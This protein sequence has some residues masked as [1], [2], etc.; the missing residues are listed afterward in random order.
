VIANL[1]SLEGRYTLNY[2]TYQALGWTI[3]ADESGTTF[4]NNTTHHGVFVSIDS[5]RTF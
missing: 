3:A 1:G 4:T 5:V 2:Q